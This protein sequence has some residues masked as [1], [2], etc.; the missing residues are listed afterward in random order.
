ESI[1]CYLCNSQLN[2][3]CAD[4]IDRSGLEPVECS[5]SVLQNAGS[6]L[7]KGVDAVGSFFGFSALPEGPDLKF[8]CQKI[9]LSDQSGNKHTFRTCSVA[10]SEAVDPC[11]MSD[12]V[13]KWTNGKGKVDFCETCE[14]DL[15]NGASQHPFTIISVFAVP[16]FAIFISRWI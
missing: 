12:S 14:T 9:D 3:K 11:A 5:K 7:K 6:A 8:A 13:S 1:K 4:P 10:K 15:C 2:P 16:C